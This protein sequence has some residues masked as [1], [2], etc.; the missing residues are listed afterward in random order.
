VRSSTRLFFSLAVVA[1]L[2][3]GYWFLRRGPGEDAR[4]QRVWAWLRS[5]EKHPDWT[6]RAGE[7]CQSAPFVFPTDGFIGYLWDDSFRP[8]HRHQGLD[9]F[10]GGPV[11]ETRVVAA[12]D[13]YLTRLAS[14]KSALIIR[15][16][17]DPLQ[18]AS[19]QPPQ[20]QRQI[21]IYYTHMADPQGESL[22]SPQFPP[23]THDE[24]VRAGTLLGTQGNFSGDPGSPVGVHLHFSIVQDDG[25]GH[26][27]NELDIK[28]TLDP[29]PY[30]NLPLNSRDNPNN[31][32]LV[33]PVCP[34]SAP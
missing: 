1:A 6:I 10:G 33:I 8:G 12:H 13:G 26:F 25:Q 34:S 23:G 22:I 16:P 4:S 15:I 19:G 17:E 5:P 7:R 31:P 28:N 32:S 30:F 27:M 11:G 18:S 3:G 21:W 24:F 9:I 29:S 2:V 14:W 20:R